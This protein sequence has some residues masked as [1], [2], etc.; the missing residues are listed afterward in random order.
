MI[1]FIILPSAEYTFVYDGR[2]D[3]HE[4]NRYAR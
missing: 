3:T 4:E 1:S 2:Y